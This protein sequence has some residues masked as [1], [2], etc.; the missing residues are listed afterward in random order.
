MRNMYGE[1]YSAM[2]ILTSIGITM[3]QFLL[4]VVAFVIALWVVA[5]GMVWCLGA[6]LHSPPAVTWRNVVVYG[7]I[8]GAPLLSFGALVWLVLRDMFQE[9]IREAH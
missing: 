9:K 2:K 3:A 5:F 6:L 4:M 1:K 7:A 8:F